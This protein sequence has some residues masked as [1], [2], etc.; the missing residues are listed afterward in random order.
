VIV[1]R[2]DE[3]AAVRSRW[4][5][6]LTGPWSMREV[7][8][9]HVG[10]LQEPNVAVVAEAVQAELDGLDAPAPAA[11]AGG[12]GHGDAWTYPTR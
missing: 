1:A 2:D 5:G 9:D 11:L 8:G 12:T 6:F 4:T 10:M 7:P 3:Y